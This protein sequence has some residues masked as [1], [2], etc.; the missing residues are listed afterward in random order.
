MEPAIEKPRPLLGVVACGGKSSRMGSD[1]GLLDYFGQPQRYRIYE[2]LLPYCQFVMLSINKDQAQGVPNPYASV[3][4]LEKYANIGPMAS[5]LTPFSIFPDADLL[6]IGC[7]YP[8]ISEPEIDL[9]L[10]KISNESIAAGFYNEDDRYEPLLAWYSN[11]CAA[12]LLESYENGQYSL[13]CFLKTHGAQKYLPSNSNAV[14]SVDR[15][16]QYEQ[17]RKIINV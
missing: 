6:V 13:Q 5:I 14:I 15:P 16:E 7:D 1:K 2:M 9:F 17:I 4:D 12:P 11:K 8:W 3:V 10:K